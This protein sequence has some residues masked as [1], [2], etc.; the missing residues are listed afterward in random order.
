[1]A[2]ADLLIRATAKLMA[3]PPRTPTMLLIHMDLGASVG[4]QGS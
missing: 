3:E 4:C 1:M 2:T